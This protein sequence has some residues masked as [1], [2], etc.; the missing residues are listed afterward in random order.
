MN[1]LIALSLLGGCL[2]DA[3]RPAERT[4][5]QTPMIIAH[6]GYSSV[7]PENTMAA[8][9]AAAQAGFGFELD[10]GFCKDKVLCVMHDETLDRTTNGVGFV[11]ETLWKDVQSKDAGSWFGEAFAAEPVPTLPAVLERFGGEVFIDVEIKS[12]R[13]DGPFTA[14]EL[15]AAVAKAIVD[16]GVSDRVVV[17]SFSPYVLEAV[18]DAAPALRRGQL[19][20][21]FDGADLNLI[22]KTVLKNLWLNGKAEA[23]FLAVED[24]VITAKYIQQMHEKGYPVFAWTVNEADRMQ[25]LVS[26]GID[27]LIT[28]VP[29]VAAKVLA[30]R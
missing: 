6:R 22:E 16:A 27:G 26:W 11:D 7:A 17:T 29:E 5:A 20:G 10:V 24:K 4:S 13:S 3:P 8:F 15:G 28:D 18:K 12:P 14:Q 23:D 2:S 9:Q 30:E 25:E 21:S 19:T 1:K